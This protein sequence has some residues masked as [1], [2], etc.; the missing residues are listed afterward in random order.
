MSLK[1]NTF[2]ANRYLR[3]KFVEGKFLLASEATDL[4]L[5]VLDLLREQARNMLGDVAIGE[6]WKVEKL[7]AT[8]LLIKP[9][10]AWFKGLPFSMRGG[11]DQLVSGATLSIGTVPVGVTV[12]DDATGDGKVLTFGTVGTP[13]GGDVT[14]SDTYRM[15]ITAREELITDLQDEFLQNAN[16]TESTQQKVRLVFQLNIIPDA[17]QDESPIP[18]RDETSVGTDAGLTPTNF[19]DTGND[20]QPNFVNEIVINPTVGT[21]DL[22]SLNSI[23]GAEQIDGRDLELIINNPIGANPIPDAPTEQGAF[24][25]G[26]LID[27]NGSEY[28]IN[29]ITN[30]TVGGRVKIVIDKEYQQEDPVIDPGGGRPYSIFKRDVYVTDDVNG[31]PTGKI[32]WPIATLVW[33]STNGVAHESSISDLRTSFEKLENYTAAVDTKFSLKATDGGTMD[34]INSTS[35][36]T[37]SADIA[38]LNPHGPA[39][40]VTAASVP[41]VDGG[42]LM[43]DLKLAAGGALELGT[44][45]VNITAAGTSNTVDPVVLSSARVGNIIVD[46]GG[47]VAEITAINDVTNIITTGTALANTGAATIYL[48]SYGPGKAPL[49][50]IKFCLAS[51]KGAKVYVAGLELEDGESGQIGDGASQELLTFVGSTGDA[52]DSPN[53]TTNNFVTDGNSLVVAIS[54]LDAG[55][56]ALS[57]TVSAIP[58]KSTAANFA[59]LPAVGN[60][61]GDVRL[62]L[63]TRVAYHWDNAGTQWLPL[64]SS[65]AGIKVIGGGTI[66]WD[67]GTDNLSFTASMFLEKIGLSYADNSILIV[68][69]PINL[70]LDKDVAYVTPNVATGGPNLTVTVSTLAAAP[71]NAVI[72]AR[73]D[74]NDVIVGSS[75]IRLKDG[76]S[77][78]LYKGTTDQ[79]EDKL[80]GQKSSFFRS[81]DPVSW[82][83]S[84][85]VFGTDIVLDMLKDDGTEQAYTVLTAGSPITLT[86]G[87]YAY[88]TVDRTQT[89]QTLTLTVG[90]AP[91]EATAGSEVVIFGKRQD[92][93]GVGYLH[94]PLH[95]QVL[96][97]GQAVR[98]GASGGGGG[99]IK[100]DYLDPISTILPTGT[101]V[102]ID[103]IAGVNGDLVLFTNLITNNN[104]VYEL[105]GVGVALTWTA[106]SAFSGQFDPTD[107]DTARILKGDAF[108]EQLALF[109]ATDFKVN[110]IVRY[111]DGVSG[112]FWELSSIKTTT[113]ANNTTGNIF[114]VNVTGSENIIVSYS[115]VRGT[116]KETGEIFITSDGTSVNLSRTNAFLND[117]GVDFSTTI[118]TGNLELNYTSD[119]TSSGTMKYFVKRWSNSTGGP[120]GIPN[121]SGATGGTIPAAGAIGEIQF[122]GSSGNLDADSRLSW[123]STEGAIDLN[124]LKYTALSSATTINDNQVSAASV[125]N[126]SNTSF[127]FAVVEYSVERNGD[128]RTGRLLVSNDATTATGFSDDF[129]ETSPVGVTFSAS[130]AAGT[131]NINYTST[132][133]GFT[134]TFKYTIRK[135]I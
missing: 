33:S 15:V 87:Q 11:K 16:L 107:G 77:K 20:N 24:S 83:G 100:V 47:V 14:L 84:D 96:G 117:I 76:E 109:D 37:W 94:L 103:G 63:D 35:I 34:Y 93:S 25:H 73:R 67:D 6:A 89:S 101:T 81:D 134:G 23:T 126:Y 61:D 8:Q 62:V 72:I 13:N 69:S 130:N 28:H 104:R 95:K 18:Y 86:A 58:W 99:S 50:S 74:G 43:Y 120:T 44:V 85:I 88:L 42:S 79:E 102:T 75:S 41:I 91:A 97:P 27:S 116:G 9:G 2:R 114:S 115:V 19:P 110:D 70:P 108:G 36:L 68:Q 3:S 106:T 124:G 21:G 71:A 98:L 40:S 38:L 66:A 30:D 128:F 10:E 31:I 57:T 17:I 12:A 49:S 82:T 132:S 119:N 131:V 113:I 64:T 133:T 56:Q 80:Y 1:F 46:S 54:A 29:F 129:V 51:R 121:Y 105:G 48:D 122:H 59:A 78:E 65:G 32:H 123:D 90:A 45:A 55:L 112:D 125:I 111:F 39:M 53:Y 127:K 118:N 7:S 22:V 135:W 92:V 5:E 4:E 52:D 60:V 26:I